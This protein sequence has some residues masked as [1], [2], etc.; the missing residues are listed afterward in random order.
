MHLPVV[1]CRLQLYSMPP[2]RK[3]NANKYNRA[4]QNAAIQLPSVSCP[5]MTFQ[6]NITESS[7][8]FPL[9]KRSPH[10]KSALDPRSG[11][12]TLLADLLHH[13]YLMATILTSFVGSCAK[14]LQDIIT[15]EAIL[16]LGVKEELT[17]LQRRME[18]IQ[19]F[20]NDAEQ[21]S[22][23]ESAINNWLGQLR[24]VMYDADDTIDLARSKGNKILP[25]HSLSSS[26]SR[27]NTCSG[28]FI[29]SCFSNIQTRHEIAVKIRNL[30]KRIDNI[31]KDKVFLSLTNTQ[32]TETVSAPKQR[33][34]PNLAEPNLV[35]KE[36]IQAYRKVVDLVLAHK[37]KKSYKLAILGTGGVG[38]TT[39]AQ[40]VYNDQKIKGFF[41]RQAWI[42]ISKDYSEVAILQEILRRI[43]VKYMQDESIEELQSKLEQAIKGKTFFLVLDDVWKSD[44]WINLLRIPLYAAATGIILLTTRLDTISVEIGV[45][46]THRVDLMLVDVGWE[47]LWKSMEINDEKEVQHLEG[48][49]KD[50]VRRCGGLP[51][52]IKVIAR[53]L[54]RKDQSENEWKKILE[55]D[56]WSMSKLP[57]EIIGALYLSFEDLPHHL[58]QCFIYCALFPENAVIYRD[59]IIRMWVAEG[60]I[61]EE[62]GQLLEDTAEEYYFELIYRNLLQPDNLSVDLRK[63]KM[64]DLL[65]QLA[66]HLSREECFV[67]DPESISTNVMSKFRRISVVTSKD[68]VVLPGMEK[69][70]YKVR[71][72]RTSYTKSQR[73]D[74]LI[75]KRFPYIRVLDLNGSVI[76][77]VPSCIGRL[78]HLRLLDLDGTNIS[79]LPESIGCL[80]NLQILNL[81]R[82]DSLHS[83]P[84]GIIRLC[85]L[86]R[87]GLSS[88]PINQVPKGIRKLKFLNDLEGFPISSGSNNNTGM[89]DGW[90]LEE[91]GP[92]MQL[93]KLDMI[94]LERAG[95][96][97]NDSLLVK[98]RYLKEL[99]LTCTHTDES[100]A[101][102]DVINIEKTFELLIPADNLEK[103][104][105]FNFFGR[106]FP[107]WL[108][109]CTHLPSLKYLKLVDCKSCLHL[110]PFG[111]LPNL[112]YL[113][114]NGAA[115][116]T[117][118]GPEIIGHGVCN[119]TS[120]GTV[121]FPKLETFVIM[122]MPNW[123]EWTFLAEEEGTATA[124]KEGGEDGA[125]AKQK[126]EG[127]PPR[128]QMLPRLKKLYLLGCPKLTALP[129]QIGQEITSMKE[130]QLR[131]VQ[132]IKVLENLVHLS[133]G[134]LIA[135]CRGVERVS[136]I[137]LV[138]ELRIARCPNLRHVQ[139][140]GSLEQLWLYEDMKELSSLW[141]PGLKHQRQLRHG[142][143]LDVY[144]WT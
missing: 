11:N 1:L 143:D 138:R 85:S 53:V 77:S 110:P 106:R 13:F 62:D 44:P 51:L 116:V 52:A 31:S 71:T 54:S 43:E 49:G 109:T 125:S 15:D 132:S 24:D 32:P 74:D 60:F 64:H 115:A 23:K 86:R 6:Q 35:G 68:M 63:C 139:D 88:T 19:H 20:L 130:L 48:L 137:P 72:W 16:I 21:K 111:Q 102:N 18:L 12:T 56:A 129:R 92:L 75:F 67:G 9:G 26:S 73:V 50:I 136:S 2:R 113:L 94:R 28:L 112:K 141:V 7:G 22:I 10:S 30:N 69:D 78:I 36:V 3:A 123:E 134:L 118:I 58:K 29:S 66:C 120:A 127:P 90:D 46:H 27:S 101:E 84:C 70:K 79:S 91:L 4:E 47:L 5:T 65:R 82:C 122:E 103:L 98:K 119:L 114:I 142:E 25:D 40:K 108:H 81:Q 34:S 57:S 37:E 41:N 126:G 61:N 17:E 42:C 104:D 80:V 97:C 33:R 38:K 76:K 87:L 83:L 100:Y 96:C 121:P 144:T 55:K 89:Q 131:D 93:R 133:E 8:S 135:G 59:D 14:K 45:D 95:P 140:L 124:G 128:M 107:T 39:L 105:I 99:A 117:K